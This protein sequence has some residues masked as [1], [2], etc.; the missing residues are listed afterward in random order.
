MRKDEIKLDDSFIELVK[1]NRKLNGITQED[2]SLLLSISN[3]KF[4]RIETGKLKS[5]DIKTYKKLCQ[6]LDIAE[7]DLINSTRTSLLLSNKMEKDLKS[8]QESKG[9]TCK[10][11][12]IKYCIE[13]TL[14]ST[15]LEE[16]S[17]D[18]L[19][20][21]KEIISST[22]NHQLNILKRENEIYKLILN[23]FSNESDYEIQELKDAIN[24]VFEKYQ[25]IEK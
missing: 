6:I 7:K 16:I 12:A 4:S 5:I 17:V 20:E 22:Y 25:H 21:I 10:S 11:D 1:T 14:Y 23:N 13:K 19:D 15:H 24:N 8:L 2:I 18:L 3:K 9:L